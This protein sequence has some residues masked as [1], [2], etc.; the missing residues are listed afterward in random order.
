MSFI[1]MCKNAVR[2]LYAA[3]EKIRERFS[4]IL[5]GFSPGATLY[6]LLLDRSFRRELQAVL[7]GKV[8]YLGRT[9]SGEGS[10]YQLRRNIHRLEKGLIM[11]PRRQAF[12]ADYIMGTVDAFA[13]LSKIKQSDWGEDLEWAQQVL[14]EYFSVTSDDPNI[15]QARQDFLRLETQTDFSPGRIPYRSAQRPECSIP[16]DEFHSLCIRRRSVRWFRSDPV[17]RKL[18]D[19]AVLA[20][21]QAPSACN[22]QPYKFLIFDDPERARFIGDIPG[23][24]A[25]FA[26]NFPAVAVI[27]GDLSAYFSERD[28]HAIYTDG[29]L[30]AMSFIL[31]LETLGL[32]SCC[33]NWPDVDRAERRMKE[34]LKL[35][36]HERPIMLIAFGYAAEEGLIPYSQ[37]AP[38]SAIRD[39]RS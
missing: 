3:L 30:S 11:E 39:Y 36:K 19:K 8:E 38:L 22:R 13:C 20:A 32:S 37:K 25:G 12:A 29:A 2:R 27:V 14:H 34:A 21:S 6:Y 31:A 17:P 1:L 26:H 5:A 35:Q 9:Q 7:A 18:I 10:I 23:G 4:I 16:Y 15:E 24:T 33:I 28:R